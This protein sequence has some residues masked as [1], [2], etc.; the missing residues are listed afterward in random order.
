MIYPIYLILYLMLIMM[1]CLIIYFLNLFIS[2]MKFNNI[3]KKNSFECGFN[4]ISKSNIPFSLPF[5]MISLMFLIFD[6]EVVLLLPMIFYLNY[7]NFYMIYFIYLFFLLI[8]LLT[9]LFE[10]MLGYLN[11]LY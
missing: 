3:E 4:P 5:Y 6:V 2:M 8:L 9:L 10:Y 7:L 11:W 1:I